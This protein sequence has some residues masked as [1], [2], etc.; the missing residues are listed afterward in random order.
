VS[1]VVVERVDLRR[2]EQIAAALHTALPRHLVIGLRGT[3]GAGKTRLVQLLAAAAGIDPAAVTSPTYGIVQHHL[4]SRKLHHIDAYR[5]ADEDEFV[6]LG[7]EELIEDDEALV[8]IE[9][10]DRIAGCLPRGGL[11]IELELEPRAASA[12]DRAAGGSDPTATDGLRRVLLSSEDE[13]LM[14]VLRE[15]LRPLSAPSETPSR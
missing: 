7:G 15:R 13:E 6:E 2:L 12:E 14:R 10:P 5:L 4:G 11:M 8:L 1:R 9:W 3:L